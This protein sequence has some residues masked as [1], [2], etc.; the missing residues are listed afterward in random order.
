MIKVMLASPVRQT[1]AI[2]Q[3]FL[4][5]L[6][7]LNTAGLSIEYAFIDDHNE[8]SALLT[9]FAKQH[10]GSAHILPGK[11]AADYVCDETTHYW[12]ENLMWKV[13]EYKDRLMALALAR[14]CDYILLLDSDLVLQPD[15]LQHLVSLGKDIVS[16]VFW[17]KWTPGAPPLPQVWLWGQYEF[18][19]FRER[20]ETLTPE[21]KE[22]RQ[23]E[24]WQMLQTPGTYKVGGLGACTLISRKA[25]EAGVAFREIYNLG[26]VGEDRHFCVRAAA[27]GFTLYADTRYPPFHIYRESELAS[28]HEYKWRHFPAYHPAKGSL[29]LGM[30]VRN[31]S[32]RYLPA[33]LRQ[34]VQYAGHVVILDDASDDD[35]VLLCKQ[36]L[37][38]TPHTIVSNSVS[39][40]ANEIVLRKQL[41]QLAT[42]GRPDW[43]LL[44]DADERFEDT[45]ISQMP[46]LAANPY[47]D[48]IQFRLYDM[49]NE[50]H[51]RDDS[52]WFAHKQ[53][54]TFMVRY[55]PDYAY[56]WRETPQHCG[57]FPCNVPVRYPFNSNIRLQHLGWAKPEDKV[58]K[59]LRYR[60][61]DPQGRYGSKAQYLSILDPKPAL[62]H[63]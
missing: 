37:N 8:P 39:G 14:N 25:I 56:R 53:H 10:G 24:F 26:L 49:W 19:Y 27:L 1:P 54:R 57:R 46:V 63:W 20:N 17:T 62:T 61:L 51:Y 52:N 11:P 22:A 58:Y 23:Q 2:L 9:G 42:A 48:T 16:E 55:Q 44:L 35:T 13:A 47:A 21:Q 15:T 4:R 6:E 18:Y 34:A 50:T 7:Q 43:V 5:A 29:T 30:L 31:E 60:Q 59:Y 36:I 3:E 45:I 28:L 33:V 40:F 41:W 32:G 38:G 12:R